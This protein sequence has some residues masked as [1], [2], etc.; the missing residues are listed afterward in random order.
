MDGMWFGGIFWIALVALVVWAIVNQNRKNYTPP[1]K[2]SETPL[3]IIKKRYAK[4]EIT[5]EQFEEM[6]N[7]L[8]K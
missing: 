4:G 6:K 7:T 5:R 8:E 1:P 2:V 3:D